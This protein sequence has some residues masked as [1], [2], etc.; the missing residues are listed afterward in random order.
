[1]TG[2]RPAGSSLWERRTSLTGKEGQKVRLTLDNLPEVALDE[3]SDTLSMMKLPTDP[4]TRCQ[5]PRLLSTSSA[6]SEL[7]SAA[8]MEGEEEEKQLGLRS[9]QLRTLS[10]SST[11]TCTPDKVYCRSSHS[12]DVVE[13][14][15]EGREDASKVMSL[16]CEAAVNDEGKDL[17][18]RRPS[19]SMTSAAED[20]GFRVVRNLGHGSMS[21]VQQAVRTSDNQEVA[22][23]RTR[24]SDPL[25]LASACAEYEMLRDLDHPAIVRAMD[26]IVLPSQT[27]LV[28]SLFDGF[29]LW[30]TM[31]AQPDG[32]SEDVARV[33]GKQMIEAV[34]HMHERGIVH[35]DMKPDNVLSSDDLS[36]VMLI[37]FNVACKVED[38]D[39]CMAVG[40]DMYAAPEVLNGESPC[41]EPADI[42]GAGICLHLL[43]TG[44][45][46]QGPWSAEG[47]DVPESRENH[48]NQLASISSGCKKVLQDSLAR[49]PGSRASA[50]QLL[51]E[52][53]LSDG[54]RC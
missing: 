29:D 25:T 3:A 17:L 9:L 18:R 44:C 15:R 51:E 38:S 26:L 16:S 46:P 32:L 12:S 40:T 39:M 48:L 6:N 19:R 52:P 41:L 27:M 8:S 7:L 2:S 47:P 42:W 14:T 28:L 34:G 4:G 30:K 45:L 22:L 23:K 11:G 5:R 20:Q 10:T 43:L 53:W 24:S 36:N 1:M 37:D 21:F 13:M 49:E 50:E 31:R 35:R 54:R 33:L